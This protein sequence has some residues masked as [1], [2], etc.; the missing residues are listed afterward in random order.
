MSLS[1]LKCFRISGL[2]TQRGCGHSGSE[3]K[4]WIDPSNGPLRASIHLDLLLKL[5]ALLGPGRCLNG[6][7]GRFLWLPKLDEL[8]S[9]A[10]MERSKFIFQIL[11]F[12]FHQ[13]QMNSPNLGAWK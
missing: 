7:C 11:F 12:E 2:G 3:S 6:Y 5:P 9:N 4:F 8:Q 1:G 13:L 10:E